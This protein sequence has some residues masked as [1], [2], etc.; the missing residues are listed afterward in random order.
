MFRLRGQF[1]GVWLAIGTLIM[2]SLC[3]A[4]TPPQFHTDL[5]KHMKWRQIG[6][7]AF[8]G[9]IDDVEAVV[10]KSHIIFI[11]SA[12]GGIF[13]SEDNGATW[14]P[15]FDENGTSLSIGDIA[16]APTD[17]NIVWAGTGE[18]NNRQSSSW[19]D[20]VY[21]SID[22]GETWINLGLKE[23]HHIGRIVIDPR[24]P[25]IVFVA[26]LGKLW[27]PN[28]ERGL[29]R[30][31]DGGQTWK[32]VLYVNEHTGAVDMAIENNGRVVYA[33]MYQRRRRAWGFVGGG[34]QSGL[35]RS[36]DG[37]DTWQKLTNGLPP[38]QTGRIGIDIS[39]SHPN[40]VYAIIENKEG[41]VF[42]SEDR[43]KS[44]T[45]MNEL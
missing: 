11:A 37:G 23:T 32:K 10:G 19:G 28:V 42:R 15:V 35:Y 2:G 27:G 31:K 36:L 45:R 13:K 25:D 18:S 39:K 17:S 40:I 3:F 6:P 21:K 38:G 8:G 16:I 22:G 44:W 14:R 43:G 4:Q 5:F 33:A 34:P 30:T 1:I 12:S 24:N 9:R 29:F 20:G 7:A 41:G 26:A